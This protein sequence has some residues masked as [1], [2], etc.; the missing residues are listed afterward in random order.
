MESDFSILLHPEAEK[1]YLESVRWY[2]NALIGLGKEFVDEIENMFD[3]IG[4][5]SFLF[6]VKKL[7]LR[8]AV[9]KKF[10]FVIV[11]SIDTGKQ[12]INVLSVYHTSRNPAKKFRR[13]GE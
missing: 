8:E 13:K 7:K 5:N 6:P 2:E 3:R 12:T 4:K 9:V 10:P 11:F 1:E